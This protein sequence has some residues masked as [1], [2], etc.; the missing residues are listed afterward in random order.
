VRRQPGLKGARSR[1]TQPDSKRQACLAELV[2]QGE[3]HELP[4]R[5]AEK[6]SWVSPSPSRV[7]RS[8]PPNVRVRTSGLPAQGKEREIEAF[9][10][11]PATIAT[12][13]C[14]DRRPAG[15]DR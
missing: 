2:L 4:R 11:L 5:V 8:R 6:A 15:D 3:L 10:A 7:A 9:A 1:G 13:P 14:D 12:L